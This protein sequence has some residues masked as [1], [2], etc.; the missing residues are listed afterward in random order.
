M[1]TNHP[2][3]I[4]QDVIRAEGQALLD[5]R[6]DPAAIRAAVALLAEAQDIVLLTGIGK[7]GLV[8]AKVA[9]SMSSLG[10]PAVFLDPVSAAHGDLGLVREG[11]TLIAFS[12]SG[13]TAELVAI[14]PAITGRQVKL[15]AIVGNGETPI[16][17]AAV[18]VLAFGKLREADALG[19]APTTSTTVQ[20]AIGDA[21]AVAASVERGLSP[22]GFHKNHP[23]GALGRRLSRVDQVMR[24]GD[25]LPVVAE[26]AGFV[27]VIDEISAKRMGLVCVVNPQGRLVG[28]V[29]DGDVRRLL[30][31]DR[32]PRALRADEMMRRDPE[33]I[34]PDMRVTDVLENDR[35]LSRHLTLPV[36][37]ARDGLVGVLVGL[38]LL[39]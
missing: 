24:K 19:L 18:T 34:P 39:R 26:T 22:E 8:A 14:L 38:D 30:R 5:L 31:S 16:G 27:E 29:S 3:A 23:A 37:D 9:A 35:G 17:K 11:A 25:D 6:L 12:N 4:F 21:L 2:E 10:I 15:L 28:I 33:T 7:S 20:L 36:V 13:T 32:D 1:R